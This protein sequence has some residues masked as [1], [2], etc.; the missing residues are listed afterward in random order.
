MSLLA[1]H[2]LVPALCAVGWALVACMVPLI[3]QNHRLAAI[4]ILV[5][6]G[7]PILGWLTYLC[8]P[9]FGVLFLALGLSILVWPPLE[10]LRARRSPDRHGAQ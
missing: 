5:L 4:W 1:T 8:G 2:P 7:V 6:A 3:R 10:L 9:G